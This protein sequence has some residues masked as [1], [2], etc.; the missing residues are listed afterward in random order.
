[1][2]Q[3]LHKPVPDTELLRSIRDILFRKGLKATTMDLVAAELHISK[4]TLYERFESKSNMVKEVFQWMTED[5]RNFVKQAF[6]NASNILEAVITIYIEHRNNMSRTSV[7]FFRDMDNL[8]K[9]ERSRYDDLGKKRHNEMLHIFNEGVQQ[10]M[11][12]PELDYTLQLSIMSLQMESLKR[13]EKI[14]PPE[15]ER[16]NVYDAIILGFL[17]SISTPQGVELLDSII[18]EK[19]INLYPKKETNK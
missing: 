9:K 11:F 14:F 1:M 16:V 13:M 8:Y 19:G 17:R 2:N 15:I 4:R 7:E 12:R 3:D 6:A 5:H 10:G 18:E